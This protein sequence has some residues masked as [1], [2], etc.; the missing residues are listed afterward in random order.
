MKKI[1]VLSAAVLLISN[2]ALAQRFGVKGG[3]NITNFSA[4]NTS[5]DAKLG[6][7]FGP[8][9][10]FH[11]GNIF[12]L[13]TGILITNKGAKR[14][15]TFDHKTSITYLEFPVYARAGYDFGI[16][17][18][19]GTFGPYF[20]VALGGKYKT[21]IDGDWDSDKIEFGDDG[22]KRFDAG[23]SIG[24]SA[25]VSIFE[26]GLS[27][28]HGLVDISADGGGKIK[29]R[30]FMISIAYKFGKNPFRN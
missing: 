20:G 29:N 23:L 25:A 26:L 4:T 1:L 10:E 7:H 12:G 5:Y 2:I 15:G 6:L 8:T 17:R 18:V 11:F 21:K 3:I 24:A 14:S 16:T 27:Y 9:A 22:M 13:E 30:A 19:Y 28:N